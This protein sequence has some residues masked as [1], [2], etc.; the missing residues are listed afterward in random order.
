MGQ[1]F[2]TDSSP[3]PAIAAHL[4]LDKSVKSHNN[5]IAWQGWPEETVAEK[6]AVAQER[7]TGDH[8]GGRSRVPR[9]PSLA[10]PRRNR[11]VTWGGTA[12]RAWTIMQ[13]VQPEDGKGRGQSPAGSGPC[14]QWVGTRVAHGSS[15]PGELAPP[16]GPPP[17]APAFPRPSSKGRLQGLCPDPH[18][19]Q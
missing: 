2:H 4:T 9:V 15:E 14:G 19:S 17:L 12:G 6:G 1:G 11:V 16:G 7:L 3:P 8:S 13:R 18:M 10:R 5:G